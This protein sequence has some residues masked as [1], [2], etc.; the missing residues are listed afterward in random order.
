MKNALA[1]LAF[2]LLLLAPAGALC[3][4]PK[5]PGEDVFAIQERLFDRDHEVGFAA[6]YIPNEEF[7]HSFPVG[8]AYVYRFNENVSWEVGRLQYVLNASKD[9]KSDLEDDFGATPTQFDEFRYSL[10][11][12]LFLTPGYGKD[13]F[14]NRSV[15]NH[16]TYVTLGAGFVVYQRETSTGDKSDE[17]SA[18]L[19]FGLGRKYFLTPNICLNVEVRDYVN[20]RDSGVE[21]RVYLG[22][23]VGYRFN[24]SP[25]RPAEDEA[26][27]R[28]K[29]YLKDGRS[30]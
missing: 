22:V 9:L 16:E 8:L 17:V 28:L 7:Y 27:N 11:T 18:S 4:D 15:V 5:K 13:A 1:P 20:F 3:A 2:A 21:N 19:S 26:A 6:G 14:W 10:H 23:G 24:L 30:E 12:N 25:R 29:G